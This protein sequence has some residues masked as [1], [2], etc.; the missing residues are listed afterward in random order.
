MASSELHELQKRQELHR[1]ASDLFTQARQLPALQV[2]AW[3]R[4]HTDGDQ[5]LAEYVWK[6][7]RSDPGNS[8]FLSRPVHTPLVE[9]PRENVD[10][11]AVPDTIGGYRVL[12]RI[13]EGGHGVVYL[14]EQSAPRRQVA[15]KVLKGVLHSDAIEAVRRLDRER[16]IIA[17]LDHP[18]I[19][20][21]YD[22]G[23][24]DAGSPFV[25]LEYV[26]GVRITD[27]ADKVC[28]P[29][30]E[31]I[32]LFIRVC[33]A[34]QH[35]HDRGV[36]HRDIT[37]SN[38]LLVSDSTDA[39]PHAKIIDF[40]IAKVVAGFGGQAGVPFTLAG[41]PIGT[42]S[43]MSPEQARGD[44]DISVRTDV[45]SLGAVLYELLV[46]V[47]PFESRD[48]V[49]FFNAVRDP[50]I[51]VATLTARV[52]LLSERAVEVAKVRRI[53][54]KGLTRMLR[55]EL[56]WIVAKAL[57]KEPGRRYQSTT[58]FADDLKAYLERDKPVK[59]APPS[60]WYRARKFGRRNRRL[61]V[62]GMV[63]GIPLTGWAIWMQLQARQFWRD[64]TA[65]VNHA[66]FA[67]N[68]AAQRAYARSTPEGFQDAAY[69]FEQ[70]FRAADMIGEGDTPGAVDTLSNWADSLDKLEAHDAAAIAVYRR[71][72]QAKI[73]LDGE[74]DAFTRW[75]LLC[76]ANAEA[77]AGLYA[78]AAVSYQ[79]LL[80]LFE[81]NAPT[82]ETLR[83]VLG[84]LAHVLDADGKHDEAAKARARAEAGR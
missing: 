32:G 30:R 69:L 21:V 4:P 51:A 52:R 22:A 38:I 80:R 1:R 2:S 50:N 81:E 15:I 10:V 27:A 62:T 48:R 55:G 42:P 41:T 5:Q 61:I 23:T 54:E 19:A 31:R 7:I 56:S 33:E 16:E 44:A 6:L 34:V 20:K 71:A 8:E 13:G 12:S 76:L 57:E 39:A 36:I 24:T 59:A 67:F 84:R 64:S 3:L 26:P 73:Q 46:G 74:Q 79:E 37:P 72:W 65:L 29:I 58:E 82:I 60:V 9:Q 49:E 78:E 45:Y 53:T 70:G 43:Y 77:D 25:V 17:A 47:P 40:S 35:A 83:G 28:M 11:Q 66:A 75:R 68:D 18:G 63:V 14:A